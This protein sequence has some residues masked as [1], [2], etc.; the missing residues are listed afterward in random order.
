MVFVYLSKPS[1]SR[2]WPSMHTI[3]A[4]LGCCLVLLSSLSSTASAEFVTLTDETFEHQTQASTGMTTGSWLVLFGIPNCS[5]CESLKPVLAE[6]GSDE[7]L[8]ERGILTASVDCSEKGSGVCFRFSATRLPVL[9]YLHKKRMYRY[10]LFRDVDNEFR[11]LPT[12]SDLKYFME[13][14]F[15]E[16]GA[17]AIPEPP[18]ALE[19][20]MK[21]IMAIYENNPL[22]GYAIF[23]MAGMMGFTI[24]VLV[25][26]L[27]K[28]A[29]GGGETAKPKRKSSKKNK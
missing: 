23:G 2:Q 8:Y 24:L 15:V 9:V 27:I 18:S 7:E 20:L 21:P 28:S 14:G 13:T 5:N 6:L 3:V 4:L 10:P 1:A 19:A 17:E 11:T 29:M 26:T 12:A 16:A 25:A 22:A